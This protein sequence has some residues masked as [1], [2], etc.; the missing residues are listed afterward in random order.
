VHLRSLAPPEKRWPSSS[1]RQNPNA[2]LQPQ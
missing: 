2:T 1:S